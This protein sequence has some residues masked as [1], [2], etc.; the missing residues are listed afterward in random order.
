MQ[1]YTRVKSV[2]GNSSIPVSSF[3]LKFYKHKRIRS[4]FP[5]ERERE[6]GRKR[7]KDKAAHFAISHILCTAELLGYCLVYKQRTRFSFK[8][9]VTVI[10]VGDTNVAVYFF[11]LWICIDLKY[12]IIFHIGKFL[13]SIQSCF[14]FQRCKYKKF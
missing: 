4:W 10:T 2:I 12:T 1:A 14:F 13:W 5:Y 6:G 11:P 8:T 9:R 7:E 3:Q